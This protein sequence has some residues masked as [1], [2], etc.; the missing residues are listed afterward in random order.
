MADPADLHTLYQEW[1]EIPAQRLPPNHYALLGVQDYESDLDV[2]ETAAKDRSSYLHQL[3]SGPNRKIVQDLLSQVAI[4]RRTLLNNETKLQYDDSLRNPPPTAEP[5][6]AETPVAEPTAPIAN[7]T[8]A[9]NV[10]STQA[11]AT[12]APTASAAA[13]QARP[14]ANPEPSSPPRRKKKSD[15]TYHAASAGI[16]LLLVGLIWFFNRGGGGRRAANTGASSP[17]TNRATPANKSTP[18][19]NSPS[20][21][22]EASSGNRRAPSAAAQPPRPSQRRPR[23]PVPQN[24]KGSGLSSGLGADMAAIL[25][26]INKTQS[27]TNSGESTAVKINVGK[28]LK[29]VKPGEWPPGPPPLANFTSEIQKIFACDQ[30]F[31]WF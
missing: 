3:A 12:S 30:G 10:S 1:L 28:V 17:S 19:N 13:P 5:A 2:I 18:A 20:S 21:S 26:D 8:P 9:K 23:R 31:E 24:Q 29:S 16:L 7:P 14:Q 4:A 15:W 6:A 22:V 27:D 25:S 11:S